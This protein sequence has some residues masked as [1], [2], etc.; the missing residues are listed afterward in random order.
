MPKTRTV[1]AIEKDFALMNL[2]RNRFVHADNLLIIA[3]DFRILV[4]PYHPFKVDGNIA[5]GIYSEILKMLLIENGERFLGGAIIMQSE[6]AKKMYAYKFYNPFILLY[7]T[8]YDLQMLYE[9][10]PKSFV[11]PPTVKSALLRIER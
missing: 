1:N 3:C 6:A 10:N 7:H 8:F 4:L 11:L 5:Y 9:I 2:L